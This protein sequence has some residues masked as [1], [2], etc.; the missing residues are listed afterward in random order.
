MKNYKTDTEIIKEAPF[1]AATYCMC[2]YGDK[3]EGIYLHCEDKFFDT[4]KG[5]WVDVNPIK[6]YLHS[7]R[8]IAD[9]NNLNE[10]RKQLTENSKENTAT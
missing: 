4:K 2:G 9:I 1:F 3:M 6:E 5:K 7:P 10:L 8:C